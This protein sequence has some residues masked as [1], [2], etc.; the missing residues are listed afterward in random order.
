MFF[1]WQVLSVFFFNRFTPV[2]FFF[3]AF[4]EI[5]KNIISTVIIC[6]FR[7]FCKTPGLKTGA[8]RFA[9]KTAFKAVLQKCRFLRRNTGRGCKK[10]SYIRIRI[11]L[12]YSL[13]VS[14]YIHTIK[15][16]LQET[17]HEKKYSNIGSCVFPLPVRVFRSGNLP[18]CREPGNSGKK[19][20]F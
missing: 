13:S 3:Q 1:S 9:D 11:R 10:I 6:A 4:S 14:V 20:G 2:R 16:F 18:F 17:A 5:R 12:I 8:D 19:K 15:R 7:I